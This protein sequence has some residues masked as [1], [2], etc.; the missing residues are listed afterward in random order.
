MSASAGPTCCQSPPNERAG[1]RARAADSS[2]RASARHPWPYRRAPAN[3]GTPEGTGYW[4]MRRYLKEFL[5]DRRVIEEPRLEVVADPEPDHPDRAPRPKGK[6]YDK[7]WNKERDEGPL[8]TITRAQ[9]EKLPAALADDGSSSTGPCATAIRRSRRASQACR[10]RAA[11]ASCWCRSIRNTP[12]PPPPR[13]ATSLSALM[14]MRW[15]PAVRV[16][17]AL[18]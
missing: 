14:R 17:P 12:P 6:D 8:K 16:A 9:A 2:G 11:T 13:P 10:T 15:Q 18:L 5:S 4:P 3:L 1:R 7:I